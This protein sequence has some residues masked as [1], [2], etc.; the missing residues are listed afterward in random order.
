MISKKTKSASEKNSGPDFTALAEFAIAEINKIARQST[1]FVYLG[2][3]DVS[4]GGVAFTMPGQT[5]V[6]TTQPQL[7]FYPTDLYIPESIGKFFD[8]DDFKIGKNSGLLSSSPIPAEAFGGSFKGVP[9]IAGDMLRV[10]QQ[11]TLCVT[12]KGPSRNMENLF[13]EYQ[14]EVE[15]ANR[16]TVAAIG[17]ILR[18]ED[19]KWRDKMFDMDEEEK[20]AFIAK[21]KKYRQHEERVRKATMAVTSLKL[22]HSADKYRGY[23]NGDPIRF[24]CAVIGKPGN[25]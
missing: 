16:K 2:I 21:N 15:Q 14:T 20:Q 17:E 8:V 19:Q 9:G 18:E 1:Q 3:G 6:F 22:H 10:G 25:P 24:L 5:A 13:I 23:T 7:P 4:Q 11:V 12:Y